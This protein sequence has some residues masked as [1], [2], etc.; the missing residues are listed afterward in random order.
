MEQVLPSVETPDDMLDF[1]SALE[2]IH[3][4]TESGDESPS[5]RLLKQIRARTKNITDLKKVM[6]AIQILE[7]LKGIRVTK[8]QEGSLIFYLQCTDM[9]G[10]GDLWFKYKNGELDNLLHSSLVS[11]ETLQQLHAECISVK[12]TINIEDFR[13]ALVYLL[14][15]SSA[16]G[17]QHRSTDVQDEQMTSELALHTSVRPKDIQR[18]RAGSKLSTASIRSGASHESTRTTHST[19]TSQS[20]DTGYATASIL[21]EDD[22]SSLKSAFKIRDDEDPQVNLN[23]LVAELNT[24][25]VKRNK[26]QQFELYC[27]I[28]DLY[29]TKLH[30]LQSALQYYQ[31]MLECSQEL[32]DKS[33]QANAYSRLGVTYGLLDEQEK[34]FRYNMMAL[35]FHDIR[36]ERDTDICV[37]YK[38]LASSLAQ[39]DQQA[40]DAKTTYESALAVAMEIGNKTQQMDIYLELG[41]L[42]REQLHEPQKSHKYYTEMLALARDLG[43]KDKERQAYNRLGLACGDMQDYETALEWHQKDLNMSQESGDK[44]EQIAAHQNI[45]DSYMTLGKLDLARSHYQS[46]KTIAMETANKTRQMDIYLKLGDLHRKQ[47]HE[48]Q[49]SHKYYTEMLALARDLGRKDMESLAYN[50]LGLACEDMQDYEAALEWN[51]KYLKMSQESGEKTEQ[52]TAKTNL[53]ASYK[54]LGKL[55]LAR[56]H[57]QSAM[58]IAMET[59]NKTRQMDI[60]LELGDLH[61]EQ[62]H[63]PQ[64]SHMYYTEML[65]LARDLGRKDKENQAYN[66]LGLACW[67]MQD[68]EAALEWSKNFL[69]MCLESGDKTEQIT[70]H[71]NIAATCMALGKL[72]LARSHYQSAMT[73]AMETGNKQKQ[74]DI[75]MELANL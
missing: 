57:Y 4:V 67:E 44:T 13:K 48:P 5:N 32:S 26:P 22:R 20:A 56:S 33:K 61:R 58:T 12:S 24:P 35:S 65:A 6:K 1:A 23:L 53:G 59:G 36:L 39:S 38:K 15:T 43:R 54:A 60:Y 16:K 3:T 72:D 17:D 74:E 10:L 73:I 51:K 2:T 42:H 49:E 19:G 75:A 68:Y 46:A 34:A 30:N 50:R 64:E 47:L 7:R 45:A 9:S 18:L 41:D 11:E 55:D 31:N 70:A 63:E 37:A 14:T 25:A 71:Q 40:S 69:K 8:A 29:R 66:R 62:L 21:S 28:G 27:Q 52:M